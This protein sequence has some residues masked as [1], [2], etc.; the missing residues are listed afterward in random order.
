[1]LLEMALASL[2][3]LFP[4]WLIWRAFSTSRQLEQRLAR[5]DASLLND[6]RF[7][8]DR[9]TLGPA[10]TELIED[11]QFVTVQTQPLSIVGEDI[12]G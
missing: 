11:V 7:N 8:I 12:H 6:D 3:L 10:G 9:V 4:A 5:G 2:S 1:M